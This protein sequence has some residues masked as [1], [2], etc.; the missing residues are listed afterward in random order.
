MESKYQE[1][2]LKIDG[3]VK[4]L[5]SLSEND[6]NT[7]AEYLSAFFEKCSLKDMSTIF[8]ISSSE[9][10]LALLLEA[11]RKTD[12]NELIDKV[13]EVKNYIDNMTPDDLIDIYDIIQDT[14]TSEKLKR[15]EK[16]M[17]SLMKENDETNLLSTALINVVLGIKVKEVTP[18]LLS[19]IVKK[20]N[21]LNI[22][23]NNPTKIY[24]IG[25]N[26]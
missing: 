4:E 17:K 15:I 8:N 16:D 11:D 23:K 1:L 5:S 7:R 26:K 19:K 18:F 20:K 10:L 3:R 24:P 12:A 25:D 14:E 21:V 22:I 13:K 9:L 2:L 6:N